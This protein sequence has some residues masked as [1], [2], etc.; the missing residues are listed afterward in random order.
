[1]ANI[2]PG[3]HVNTGVTLGTADPSNPD[4]I[5]ALLH[6]MGMPTLPTGGAPQWATTLLQD[7]LDATRAG[8]TGELISAPWDPAYQQGKQTFF[9]F[10]MTDVS[11]NDFYRNIQ[12]AEKFAASVGWKYYPPAWQIKLAAQKG[13]SS[14]QAMNYFFSTLPQDVQSAH[15]GAKVGLDADAY[16]AQLE[17]Y[18]EQAYALTGNENAGSA[19]YDQ[20]IQNQW[21][22][23][24][25][26]NE[27][28]NSSAIQSQYGFVRYGYDF[29]QWQQY[30]QQTQNQIAARFGTSQISNDQAFLQ[31]LAHPLQKI[32]SAVG[33]GQTPL[34]PHD[35][36]Q[37]TSF[38]KSTDTTHGSPVR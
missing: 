17:T 20:A 30:K 12:Y 22:G 21:S 25:L 35:Q 33:S 34:G 13:M 11:V 1:M 31:D 32:S 15:P 26:L 10:G 7:E 18:K 28:K 14:L 29:Q 8:G 27:M 6:Q 37:A 16:N 9:P 19:F 5:V 2:T 38:V 23:S 3:S 4:D 36:S 24:Q